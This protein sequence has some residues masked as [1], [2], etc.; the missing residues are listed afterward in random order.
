MT[1]IKSETAPNQSLNS[2]RAIL[3]LGTKAAQRQDWLTLSNYLKQLPQKDGN[4]AQKFD[5]NKEDWNTAVNL[6][7][8]ILIEADFTHKWSITKLL[9]G[10][11]EEI[12]PFLIALVKDKTVEADVRWFVCQT[13][14][15]FSQPEVVLTLVELLDSTTDK[16]LTEIAGKTLTKIGDDAIDALQKLLTQPQHRVLAVQSLYYI[17]T[18][19][20]IEPL[21]DIAEK[22]PNPELKAIAIEALGSFH[23]CRIA[24]ILIK[25]LQ[26]KASSVRR[27]ATIALGFRADLADELD[28]V[29]HLRPLL[30][31]FNLEVCRQ[32]A[33]SLSRM[34]NKT[35]TAAIFEVLQAHTTPIELKLDLVKALSWSEIGSSIDYLAKALSYSTSTVTVEIITVLGRSD[36]AELKSQAARTLVDFWN[37]KSPQLE[38]SQ[39]KQSLATSLGELRCEC[40]REVLEQLT[41][42]SDR[43]VK[44]YAV[45]ALKKISSNRSVL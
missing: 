27:Y 7:I 19:K 26:D 40:G 29:K 34:K 35:A 41:Q 3:H 38:L 18:V 33:I 22:D 15:N 14:G 39:I 21:L 24:P 37:S 4:K 17:R 1:Y 36:R 31:D 45:S 11:G 9:P 30:F 10:F 8:L 42:D 44:L 16:E 23:D 2:V 28:L 13:L 43:K 12:I 25:A 20:T 5:L 32:A 6:A